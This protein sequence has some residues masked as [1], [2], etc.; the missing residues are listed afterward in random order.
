MHGPS[1]ERRAGAPTAPPVLAARGL[2]LRRRRAAL[3]IAG[4]ALLATAV[5]GGTG[6]PLPHERPEEPTGTRHSALADR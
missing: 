3:W 1:G 4:P 6:D 5:V 2:L